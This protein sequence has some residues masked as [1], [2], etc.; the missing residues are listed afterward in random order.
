VA[1]VEHPFDVS[2]ITAAHQHTNEHSLVLAGEIGFR[3]DD[4]EV[5]S[6]PAVTSPNPPARCTR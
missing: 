4:T 3:S 5:A 2:L 6:V 1:I